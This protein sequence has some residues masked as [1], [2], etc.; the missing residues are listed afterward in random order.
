M[1]RWEI[2][3]EVAKKINQRLKFSGKELELFLLG[4]I[5]PDV[6]NGHLVRN[7]SIK[8]KHEFTHFTT[9]DYYSYKHFFDKYGDVIIK[10]P[11][12][13]GYYVHLYLD[14]YWNQTFYNRIGENVTQEEHDR[15]NKFKQSDFRI[16][17]YNFLENNIKINDF[18][19]ILNECKK[20]KEIHITLQ[21]LENIEKYFLK[22]TKK[23]NEYKMYREEELDKLFKDSVKSLFD[24]IDKLNII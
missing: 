3:L 22:R 8:Y 14:Y 20:I 2:H 9:E 15:L 1:P 21:D 19:N 24:I 10:S 12:L 11:L 6:N 17:G 4:N 23:L 13:L 16:Y 5:L 18:D 7:I